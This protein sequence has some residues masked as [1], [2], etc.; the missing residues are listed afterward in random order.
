M[1]LSTTYTKILWGITLFVLGLDVFL[2]SS[3]PLTIH[4][5]IQNLVI[6]VVLLS[7]TYLL[8]LVSKQNNV[9]IKITA[10]FNILF[11]FILFSLAIFLFQYLM[12][13]TNFP[14]I[15]ET[16]A[17]IDHAFGFSVAPLIEWF[18]AHYWTYVSLGF[19][20]NTFYYQLPFVLGYFIFK[21]QINSIQRFLVMYML[22]ALMSLVLAGFLPA[23]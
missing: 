5:N 14:L 6:S 13:T 23:A 2:I 16:Y 17:A 19:I 11:F 22:G 1:Q 15:D 10:G 7:T 4:Y 18:R 12:F 9:N 3:S 8:Y 21:G 20:Y